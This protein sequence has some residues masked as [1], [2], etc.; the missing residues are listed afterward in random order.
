[1]QHLPFTLV[2]FP[3]YI[4]VLEMLGSLGSRVALSTNRHIYNSIGSG[5][6]GFGDLVQRA[7]WMMM[8]HGYEILLHYIIRPFLG[9]CVHSCCPNY[10]NYV[11]TPFVLCI[12]PS[13]KWWRTNVRN[14]QI[15]TQVNGIA[16]HAL[17]RAQFLFYFLLWGGGCG[18]NGFQWMM[19]PMN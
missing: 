18:P 16:Q 13:G 10:D 6:G 5:P 19:L 7:G 3:S 9:E 17:K 11:P 8:V 2:Q 15:C 14:R 12:I 1:M 4:R